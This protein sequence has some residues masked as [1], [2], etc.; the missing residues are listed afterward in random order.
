MLR[1]TILK[2]VYPNASRTFLE[3]QHEFPSEFGVIQFFE[4][5]DIHISINQEFYKDGTN[6]LWQVFWR[7]T[8]PTS[9]SLYSGTGGYGD[10]GEYPTFN[11]AL[12]DAFI[13]CME[14]LEYK[15]TTGKLLESDYYNS[16][17]RNVTWK[18]YTLIDKEK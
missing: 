13:C 6:N 12:E 4:Q 7:L 1:K 11:M 9:D 15:L 2:E 10:N 5:Y 3:R 16:L 8:K 17:I 14:L 18:F